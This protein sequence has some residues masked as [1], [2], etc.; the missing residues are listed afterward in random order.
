MVAYF[1][2]DGFPSA[3]APSL[4]QHLAPSRDPAEFSSAAKTQQ[5]KLTRGDVTRLCARSS[6]FMRHDSATAEY[7]D[8]FSLY[9]LQPR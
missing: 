8:I 6:H 1:Y 2:S 3:R 4:R 9:D 5:T 7:E